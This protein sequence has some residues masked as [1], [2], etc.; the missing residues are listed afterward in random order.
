M[1]GPLFMLAQAALFCLLCNAL[2]RLAVAVW[3]AV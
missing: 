2:A 1:T 3:I